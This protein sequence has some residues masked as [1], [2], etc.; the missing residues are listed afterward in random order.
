MSHEEMPDSEKYGIAVL[1]IPMSWSE[2]I[3]ESQRMANLAIII[4]IIL[5]AVPLLG[6]G[7]LTTRPFEPAD[8]AQI[9]SEA[10]TQASQ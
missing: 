1:D 9:P 4:L 10:S 7:F 3:L 2:K 5:V 6:I 8:A